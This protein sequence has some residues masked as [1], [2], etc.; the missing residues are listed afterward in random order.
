M[1]KLAQLYRI[2]WNNVANWDDANALLGKLFTNTDEM[3]QFIYDN[4]ETNPNTD[5]GDDFLVTQVFS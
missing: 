3:F 4:L 5:T 1:P 2:D